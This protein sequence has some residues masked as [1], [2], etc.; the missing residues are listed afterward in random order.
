MYFI[1]PK[2]NHSDNIMWNKPYKCIKNV[3]IN[4]LQ[5]KVLQVFDCNIEVLHKIHYIKLII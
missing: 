2:C 5:N 1:H 4:N 3:K